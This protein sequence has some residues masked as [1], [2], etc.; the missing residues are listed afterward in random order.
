MRRSSICVAFHPSFLWL[1]ASMAWRRLPRKTQRFTVIASEATKQSSLFSY[2]GLLRFAR[3][4][5][6]ATAPC[7]RDTRVVA[8]DPG[9]EFKQQREQ[10]MSHLPPRPGCPP[11][12]FY[13]DP[14]I[15]A[16]D[17]RFEKYWLKLSAVERLTPRL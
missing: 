3:N 16:L 5:G 7:R 2:P 15:H 1:E 10:T 17:P 4:D 9:E 13:P 11:A 8:N 12:T 14:A 6:G